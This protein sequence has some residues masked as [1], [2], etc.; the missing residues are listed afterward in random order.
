M[1]G[2][3][4]I[5]AGGHEW[6]GFL[7]RELWGGLWSVLQLKLG[8]GVVRVKLEGSMYSEIHSGL[9]RR[10]PVTGDGVDGRDGFNVVRR[11]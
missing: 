9:F 8:S 11:C 3:G 4:S 5:G 10:P 2:L 6:L 1:Y 7:V